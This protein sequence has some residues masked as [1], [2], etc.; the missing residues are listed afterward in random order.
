M[1]M[2]SISQLA[3]YDPFANLLSKF[4]AGRWQIAVLGFVR[5]IT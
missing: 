3:D 2:S 4:I 1:Y 5:H